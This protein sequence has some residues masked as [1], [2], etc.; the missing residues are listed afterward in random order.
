MTSRKRRTA[1]DA[2]I[3]PKREAVAL[4][5]PSYICALDPKPCFGVYFF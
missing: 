2:P 4:D 1:E 3:R 5:T